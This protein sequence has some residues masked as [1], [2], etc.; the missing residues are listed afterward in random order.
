MKA[1]LLLSLLS[2]SL[3]AGCDTDSSM[4]EGTNYSSEQSRRDGVFLK[5]YRIS[6]SIPD[7]PIKEVFV[8]QRF[9]IGS[10]PERLRLLDST[11]VTSN[12]VIVCT[13][14]VQ[15]GT[16]GFEWDLQ[17][18]DGVTMHDQQDL[19]S[20]ST[21]DQNLLRFELKNRARFDNPTFPMRLRLMKGSAT[22]VVKTIDLTATPL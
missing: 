20:C 6:P 16:P 10:H 4:Y 2:M 9:M 3:L 21:P 22:N 19:T 1:M 13:K 12:L 5:S 8:E 18:A 14:P 11:V 7:L 15:L 17:L